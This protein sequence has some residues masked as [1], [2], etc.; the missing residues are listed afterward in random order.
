MIDT[1]TLLLDPTYSVWGVPAVIT[2]KAGDTIACS[3]FDHRDGIDVVTA[4]GGQS[5]LVPGTSA[6]AA[7]V[8]VRCSQCPDKPTGGTIVLND[9]PVSYRIKSSKQ[10]GRP[11]VGE[12]QLELEE[13]R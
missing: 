4:R 2:T 13:V 6:Q 7:I 10:K 5:I 8:L 1:Q 3:V 9:E 11:V 12:W